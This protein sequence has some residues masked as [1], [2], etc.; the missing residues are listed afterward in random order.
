MAVFLLLPALVLLC[1]V[2]LAPL[3]LPGAVIVAVVLGAVAII[4]RH[5]AHAAIPS[6]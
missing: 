2:L 1:V 6:H 3:M 5:H 4:R